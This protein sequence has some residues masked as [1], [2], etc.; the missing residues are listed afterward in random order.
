VV[1]GDLLKVHAQTHPREKLPVQSI[2]YHGS[3]ED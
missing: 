1:K 3:Y 2:N